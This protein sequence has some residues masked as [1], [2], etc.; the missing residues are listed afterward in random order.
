MIVIHAKPPRSY[1]L[2]QSPFSFKPTVLAPKGDLE[3]LNLCL[4]N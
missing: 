4:G 3:Q 2:G 1:W